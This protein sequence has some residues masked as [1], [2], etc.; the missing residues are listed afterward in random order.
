MD[1]QALR[2][3]LA[4]Q[5]KTQLAS[6]NNGRGIASVARVTTP[7]QLGLLA[8]VMFD[9][10]TPHQ[11]FGSGMGDTDVGLRVDVLGSIQSG[12][13]EG[14][15]RL[16]D[17]LVSSG[18]MVDAIYADTTLDGECDDLVVTRVGPYDTLLRQSETYI[19][20]PFYLTC[21]GA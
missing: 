18:A 17:V 19:V 3:N 2:T 1:V 4:A 15:E 16:L 10:L 11:T 12:E 7:N 20:C 14:T 8:V 6:F 21:Y 9:G 13:S 5:V